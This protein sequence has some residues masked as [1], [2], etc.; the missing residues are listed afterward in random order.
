MFLKKSFTPLQKIRH[1]GAFWSLKWLTGSLGLAASE[2]A[3]YCRLLG[4]KIVIRLT[5]AYWSLLGLRRAPWKTN[6][7]YFTAHH[8][9]IYYFCKPKGFTWVTGPDCGSKGLTRAY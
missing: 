9:I 5:K 1:T 7:A 3:T 6:P 4:L 8:F 2:K